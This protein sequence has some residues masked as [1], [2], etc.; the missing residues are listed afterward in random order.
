MKKIDGLLV[1]NQYINWNRDISF[2]KRKRIDSLFIL[3][4]HLLFK[5]E[6]EVIEKSLRDVKISHACFGD[7]GTDEELAKCDE[8]SYNLG[9]FTTSPPSEFTEKYVRQKSYFKNKLIYSSLTQ[10]YEFGEIFF[11]AVEHYQFN[12]GIS[13]NF[14]NELK[15]INISPLHFQS[16]KRLYHYLARNNLTRWLLPKKSEFTNSLHIIEN[17]ENQYFFFS[18]KRLHF[19][20]ETIVE[21]LILPK[22]YD[23][24]ELSQIITQNTAKNKNIYICVPLHQYAYHIHM[25]EKLPFPIL[26]FEDAFRPSNYTPYYYVNLFIHGDLVVRDMFDFQLF[27]SHGKLCHL[28]FSFIEKNFFKLPEKLNSSN[29]K[30]IILSLNHAGDWTA[31]ISRSDTDILIQAFV[32]LAKA[33]TNIRCVIRLHPTMTRY[34]NEGTSSANRIKKM[35]LQEKLNNLSVSD[36]SLEEDWERGDLFI[37]EYSLSV[38]DAM[39]KG[40]LGLFT[41]FTNRRSFMV[42]YIKIGM[43]I[44]N[45]SEDLIPTIMNILEN[46][47]VHWDKQTD[48]IRQY[49]KMLEQFLN[50][51]N[52]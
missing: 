11:W 35:V 37:T 1:V 42:D 16:K 47:Q 41:N 5:H 13:F 26:I 18:L 43:P 30:T 39:K 29:I 25:M 8:L 22:K 3:S 6:R 36:V 24:N 12:L 4:S 50:Q 23:A 33:I 52:E 28:P 2:L 32:A 14:W 19:T 44:V 17:A 21:P 27:S 34:W 9:N 46:P 31:L 48:T 38:I 51:A 10:D 40:K 15:G 7:F 45:K 20:E 49:N